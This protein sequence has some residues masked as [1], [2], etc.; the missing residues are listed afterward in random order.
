[1]SFERL[2]ALHRDK[3][4][5]RGIPTGFKDLDNILAGLQRSDLFVLAA[6]PSM[7]KAQPLDAQV[8]P[9][10]GWESMRNVA[11][12]NQLAS[13]DGEPSTVVGT[14]RQGEQDIYSI[15]F[16]DGRVVEATRD[17]LWEV[18]YREWTEPRIMTTAE[19]AGKLTKKRY[20][21]RLWIDMFNGKF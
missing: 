6:R 12:G 7:G 11:I 1:E 21:G 10:H 19:I 20:Q 16:S 8:L 5:L 14:L 9:L 3:K 17:H 4:K 15:R 2:D 18:Q 13:I